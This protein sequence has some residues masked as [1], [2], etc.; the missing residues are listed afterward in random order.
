MRHAPRLFPILAVACTL[1]TSGCAERGVRQ[2]EGTVTL[3]DAPLAGADVT[4]E[5]ADPADL[6]LGAFGGQTGPDGKF[7][8]SLGPGTGRN[9]Q[10]GRFV[11]LIT[12]GAGLGL[13]APDADEEERT[14][15]LMKQTA[16]G[17]SRSSLPEVYA[18]RDRSPFRAD[19]REG[20]N[21]VGPFHLRS[22]PKER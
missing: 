17:L 16:P 21:E 9:A 12:K 14:R 19:V 11:V 13:P 15:E 3:D 5:P 2:V 22:R 6:R 1:L 10:P 8:I 7:R 20:V 4:F 18:D